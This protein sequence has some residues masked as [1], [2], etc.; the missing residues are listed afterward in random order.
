MC[1]PCPY[2]T[3][4]L[5]VGSVDCPFYKVDDGL[6]GLVYAASSFFFIIGILSLFL[7]KKSTLVF[8]NIKQG[9]HLIIFA[10]IGIITGL[11]KL[12]DLLYVIERPFRSL[13]LFIPAVIF[14]IFPMNR[15][16]SL[17][18]EVHAV[19]TG[20]MSNL[21]WLKV[22][23][24][25]NKSFQF[26]KLFFTLLELF[27]TNS[28]IQGKPLIAS[29]C[30]DWEVSTWTY[31]NHDNLMKLFWFWIHWTVLIM[32]QIVSLV[33]SLLCIGIWFLLGYLLHSIR[34]LTIYEVLS[35]IHFF[36]FIH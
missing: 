3:S 6:L 18:Y 23:L 32:Q 33:L 15:F 17:L 34:L 25:R 26:G 2:L 30:G 19:P 31:E 28:F 5:V 29:H 35:T 36:S 22:N 24:D 16:L 9:L 7:V 1:T 8:S 21:L 27:L 12:T 13:G 4:N 14:L 20:R 10:V 11:D